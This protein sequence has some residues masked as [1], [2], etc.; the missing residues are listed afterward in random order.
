MISKF[1]FEEY[2]NTTITEKIINQMADLY[3]SDFI[4][5]E[6]RN[7][8]PEFYSKERFFKRMVEYGRT[9]HFR[10][11]VCWEGEQIVGFITAANLQEGTSW[12]NNVKTELSTEDLQENSERTTAIFDLLVATSHRGKGIASQLHEQLVSG[13][14]SERIT[15]L[16]S[17]PQQPAHQMWLNKGYQIIGQVSYNNG[18]LLDVFIRDVE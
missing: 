7:K 5:P 15:L 12:W 3:W 1:T 2:N 11:I 6:L 9:P 4:D 17:P 8:N 13:A 14:T 10:C 16:S 18:P